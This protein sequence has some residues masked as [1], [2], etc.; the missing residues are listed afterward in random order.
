MRLN[1]GCQMTNNG[2]GEEKA[3]L[4]VE[5]EPASVWH[6]S[7]LWLLLIDLLCILIVCQRDPGEHGRCWVQTQTPRPTAASLNPT[8]NPALR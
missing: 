4:T 7:A 8:V 5:F 6:G 1:T 3:A 2:K